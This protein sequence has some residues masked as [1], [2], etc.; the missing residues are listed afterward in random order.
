MTKEKLLKLLSAGP[1]R[2]TYGPGKIIHTIP[3]TFSEGLREAAGFD[4]GWLSEWLFNKADEIDGA[5]EEMYED[6]RP[7]E[8]LILDCCEGE[9][10]V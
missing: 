9:E 3:L 2:H 6:T 1:I 8:E 4:C 5:L 7:L 10:D